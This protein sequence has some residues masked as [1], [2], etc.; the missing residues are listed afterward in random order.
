MTI[1]DDPNR[2]LPLQLASF[3]CGTIAFDVIAMSAYGLGGAALARRM[4]EPRFRRGFQVVVGLL[5]IS[6]A[7]LMALRH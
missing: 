4:T 2:P 1:T 3:A 6:A 7:A 5:L